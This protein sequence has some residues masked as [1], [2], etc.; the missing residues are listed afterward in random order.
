M[1]IEEFSPKEIR[2]IARE[3]NAVADCLPRMEMETRDFDL[4][5]IETP[6]PM[7][8]YFNMLDNMEQLLNTL[9][10]NLKE[11]IDK[12]PCPQSPK[13]VSKAQQECEVLMKLITEDDRKQLSVKTIEG[14]EIAHY[15]NKIYIS[16]TLQI[17]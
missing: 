1:I 9:K 3:D 4:I 13:L 12:A 16:G 6:N 2:H 5:E 10:E 11:S 15:K 7:L 8:E 14:V 17:D